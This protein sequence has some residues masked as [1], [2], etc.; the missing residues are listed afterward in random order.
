MQLSVAAKGMKENCNTEFRN[1]SRK[2]LQVCRFN[3]Y[4]LTYALFAKAPS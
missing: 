2:E 4:D 3:T 1:Y